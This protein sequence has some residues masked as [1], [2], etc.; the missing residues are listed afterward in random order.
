MPHVSPLLLS[1]NLGEMHDDPLRYGYPTTP[2][3][4]RLLGFVAIAFDAYSS[5]RTPEEENP[6]L[7]VLPRFI[8]QR[9]FKYIADPF[10]RATL[11]MTCRYM[12]RELEMY[13][14]E[15]ALFRALVGAKNAIGYQ[16]QSDRMRSLSFWLDVLTNSRWTSWRARSAIR[17]AIDALIRMHPYIPERVFHEIWLLV[18]MVAPQAI[19]PLMEEILAAAARKT[20]TLALKIMYEFARRT[21][22]DD[23]LP[24]SF[25]DKLLE[26]ATPYWRNPTT[27]PQA[28]PVLCA[29]AQRLESDTFGPDVSRWH[30]L[31]RLLPPGTDADSA[32]VASLAWT[33]NRIER[34]WTKGGWHYRQESAPSRALLSRFGRLPSPERQRACVFDD[35]G[36]W[37]VA[38]E[39]RRLARYHATPRYARDC[40][41][42]HAAVERILARHFSNAPTFEAGGGGCGGI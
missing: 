3:P 4:R 10:D 30:K 33:A 7:T 5:R 20:P 18:R 36:T 2:S 38:I 42:S 22:D 12:K 32:I 8:L 6:H 31:L 39:Q 21:V 27:Q 17:T 16:M 19:Q 25:H 41:E 24:P 40:A 28:A 23:S 1:S 14:P 15:F 34:K 11:A 29:L 35:S 13:K 37:E 9:I 26:L